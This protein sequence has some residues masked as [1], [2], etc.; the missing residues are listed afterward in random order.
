MPGFNPGIY[1]WRRRVEALQQRAGR[2]VM[3]EALRAGQDHRISS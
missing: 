3:G 2:R 1:P